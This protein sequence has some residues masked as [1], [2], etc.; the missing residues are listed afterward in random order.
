MFS[1]VLSGS[2]IIITVFSSLK[3]W[4]EMTILAVLKVLLYFSLQ[5]FFAMRMIPINSVAVGTLIADLIL[6]AA[7]VY[8]TWYVLIR[9]NRT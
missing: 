6:L 1:G 2:F 4:R 9:K 8:F 5:Y 7:L 3:S